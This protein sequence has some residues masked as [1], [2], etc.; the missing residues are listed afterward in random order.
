MCKNEGKK[1]PVMMLNNSNM[2]FDKNITTQNH[3][4][5]TKEKRF[6]TKEQQ[7]VRVTEKIWG[8]VI[9]HEIWYISRLVSQFY[10][11]FM[12]IIPFAVY[13]GKVEFVPM[14]QQEGNIRA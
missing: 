2:L 1:Q 3:M 10:S 7:N 4:C 12:K 8:K 5:Y 6:F 11:F 14:Y 9:F 13:E